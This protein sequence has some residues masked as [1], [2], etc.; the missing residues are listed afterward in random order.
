MTLG[1]YTIGVVWQLS[2]SCFECSPQLRSSQ[3]SIC[4]NPLFCHLSDHFPLVILLS[5]IPTHLPSTTRYLHLCHWYIWYSVVISQSLYL[6]SSIYT[7]IYTARTSIIFHNYVFVFICLYHCT[8]F[9][10]PTIRIGHICHIYSHTRVYVH[11]YVSMIYWTIDQVGED[12]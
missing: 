1:G 11:I 2:H 10:L 9:C 5:P 6:C 3:G 12:T 7:Y 4:G 8:L